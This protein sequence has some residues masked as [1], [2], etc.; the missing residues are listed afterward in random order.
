[1]PNNDDS[2]RLPGGKWLLA[3]AAVAVIF[4]LMTLVSGGG[5]L[6]GGAE[7]RA[8]AGNYLP[9]VVWFNFCAGFAYVAAG[10]GLWLRRPWA[11]WLA[12]LIA[13]ATLLVLAAFAVHVLGGGAYETRTLGAL[14]L[15]LAVWTAI[16]VGA[17]RAGLVA[18][19]ERS[20]G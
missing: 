16:A 14:I 2:A 11:A 20:S 8:A 7:T 6:F 12:L 1:M 4:G 17:I 15:R 18:P 10:V 5:V 3:A 9:F 19:R 13:A